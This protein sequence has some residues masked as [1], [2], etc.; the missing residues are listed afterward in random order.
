MNSAALMKGCPP[1]STSSDTHGAARY[2]LL[3]SDTEEGGERLR[4][5]E[6][7]DVA[8]MPENE[9]AGCG[10]NARDAGDQLCIPI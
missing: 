4:I 6:T 3:R 5:L 10:T 2:A 8:D 9:C 7:P 1:C